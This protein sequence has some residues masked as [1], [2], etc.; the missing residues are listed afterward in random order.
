[1]AL[2]AVAQEKSKNTVQKRPNILFIPV[3]DL[4]PEM[5]VYGNKFIKTPN[6]DALANSGVLFTSTYC[7]QAVCN[8]S[9]ASL[10]T[11]MRPDKTQVWDL[12]VDFRNALPA[13]VTLPQFYKEHGYTTLG[14]GKTFHNTIPDTISWDYRFH[15]PPWPFDADATYA[16]KE[17]LEIMS[18]RIEKMKAA[19]KKPDAL[20]V[21]YTKAQ[22][23]ESADVGDDAYYD[24]AQT[25]KAIGLLKSLSKSTKPFFLSV[26]FYKP[27]LPFNAPKKYWDL[28]DESK[29]PLA[30]NQFVPKGSP[31]YAVHGDQELRWYMDHPDLPLPAEKP[32]DEA[33]QRKLV[34]GYY[35]CV[36]YI[37]AQVGRL[38]HT[39]D[40]LGLRENTIVVLWGD[41]GWKLGDHNAWAKQTNYEVDTHV[42][43]IVSGPGVK[44]KGEKI[45]ALTEF[46]DIYPSLLEMTGF[47]VPSNLQGK[48]FVPLLSNPNLS[49]KKEAYSQFLLG[50]FGKIARIP[51]EVMGYAVRTKDFR[52][53]EWYQWDKSTNTA[54]KLLSKEL[55]DKNK[56][57]QENENLAVK[58]KYTKV[59]KELNE[60]LR[61][62]FEQVRV[63]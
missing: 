31:A 25:T 51:G 37:D 59:M 49:W 40:S 50:R 15:L 16:G 3:D 34:H 18:K 10:L 56:D 33:S 52:Y 43:M 17:N 5:G 44:A 42:P 7:Q 23:E 61:R 24:G 36:S 19:G 27:H 32:L 21:Y 46:V 57:P 28:Y 14:I 53:V 45:P 54:T 29:M 35:A 26:G 47:D 30:P 39:L 12:D 58:S 20:G 6:L 62:N 4:R 11:G 38:M 22:S 8:P 55:F 1:M 63:N 60:A 9:R 2:S 48:S 13:A 41:H